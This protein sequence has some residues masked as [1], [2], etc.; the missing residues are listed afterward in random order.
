M[1][2]AKGLK[3]GLLLPLF[4]SPGKEGIGT[5]PDALR[6]LET[7]SESGFDIWQILPIHPT[8]LGDSPFQ[9]PSL[10]AGNP[11]LIG[12]SGLVD[13]GDLSIGA[14][15]TYLR[16]WESFKAADTGRSDRYIEYGFL[17][18]EK[19]GFGKDLEGFA[20]SPLYRAY[21]GFVSNRDKDRLRKYEKFCGSESGWL[22]DYAAFMAAKRVHGFP[23]G[24]VD[25]PA[26]L[27][28][29]RGD[30][31][32]GLPRD[33][34][35]FFKYLQFVFEEQMAAFFEAARARGIEVIGD[36]PIYPAYESADVWAYR[37]LFQLDGSGRMAYAAAVPPDYFSATGQLW[38]NPLY[39]WGPDFPEEEN[40][41]AFG[42]W[43]SRFSRL[44]QYHDRI[45]FDH[46]RGTVAYGRVE[47]GATDAREAEWIPGPGR[48][49]FDRLEKDFRCA[50]R[51][52]AEDLG[53]ITQDVALL[54]DELGIPGMKIFL[55][56]DIGDPTHEYWPHHS[57]ERSNC[58]HYTG[59]HDNETLV[60][61]LAE[62]SEADRTFFLDYLSRS[63]EKEPHRQAI[64]LLLRSE[65]KVVVLPA[66]DLLGLG[67]E[68]RINNPSEA[69]GWWRRRLTGEE[70][71]RLR[72]YSDC[73]Q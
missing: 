72:D 44:F 3:T 67:A 37:E 21:R 49:L 1:R 30:F 58:F 51:L 52:I 59:T 28:L 22:V 25:W 10:F 48:V 42:W 43:R 34:I 16:Q 29:R 38:G 20:A 18:G 65:S 54:R 19:L 35:E 2:R 57:A 5:L 53:I 40:E 8:G 9:G 60:Q 50:Q 7:V 69:F 32:D 63:R 46:F 14:Y 56:A 71:E 47:A 68:A 15:K 64:D 73:S 41:R 23:L 45:K 33:L 13:A 17:W 62:M 31:V 55:F 11:N 26:D 24:W 27:A 12:L 6:F 66:Q 70:S 4:S 39:R 36:V 61:K